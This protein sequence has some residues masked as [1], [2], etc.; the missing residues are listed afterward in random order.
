MGGKLT[1]ILYTCMGV[2]PTLCTDHHCYTKMK[3]APH[4][5][6]NVL[7]AKCMAIKGNLDCRNFQLQPLHIYAIIRVTPIRRTI[8]NSLLF[9][10]FFSFFKLG[11][12][13]PF[14]RYLILY[15]NDSFMSMVET[16][17]SMLQ[18]YRVMFG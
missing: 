7:A 2:H 3:L 12:I 6:V 10:I 15:N 16:P 5:R 14:V 9:F 18:G 11:G 17:V 8:F 1:L 4:E 13:H